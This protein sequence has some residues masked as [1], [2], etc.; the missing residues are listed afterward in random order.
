MTLLGLGFLFLCVGAFASMRLVYLG[1]GASPPPS[2][3]SASGQPL[4]SGRLAA[5]GRTIFAND[6]PEHWC[7]Q[8]AHPPLTSGVRKVRFKSETSGFIADAGRRSSHREP[9]PGAPSRRNGQGRANH[10]SLYEGW[11][12]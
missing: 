6:R 1:R 8:A 11:P 4:S 10:P 3:T 9:G 2:G 12:E 7:N 5:A